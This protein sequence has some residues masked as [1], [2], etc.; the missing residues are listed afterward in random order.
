M[1]GSEKYKRVGYLSQIITHPEVV[2]LRWPCQWLPQLMLL[3][4]HTSIHLCCILAV[5]G[6]S[7]LIRFEQATRLTTD[8]SSNRFMIH[9]WS[10][11]LRRG[12]WDLMIEATALSTVIAQ[13]ALHNVCNFWLTI[14]RI[15][16]CCGE[17]DAIALLWTAVDTL[18]FI[19]FKSIC[20]L[21][22]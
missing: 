11:E 15:V 10:V 2:L 8:L 4:E 16:I 9:L 6:L 18:Q 22:I 20:Q 14:R 19:L 13:A 3:F 1:L 21:L 7:R 17:E 5:R 12:G